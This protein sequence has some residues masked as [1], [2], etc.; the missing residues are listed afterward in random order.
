[1]RARFQRVVYLGSGALKGLAR[2]AALKMLELTDGQV[3][4]AADSTLGFRHGPKTIL[5]AQSLVVVFLCNDP[6]ARRYDLD[7]VREL[8]REAVAGRVITVADAPAAGERGLR[9]AARPRHP[10]CRRPPILRCAWRTRRS[11]RRWPCCSRCRSGFPRTRPMLP[12][13]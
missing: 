7:L 3:I 2:E 10:A 13:R 5:N 1:M 8:R 6:H 12:A 9:P 4:A 11:R